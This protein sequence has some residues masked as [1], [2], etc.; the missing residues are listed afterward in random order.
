MSLALIYHR[1]L[2]PQI[3]STASNVFSASPPLSFNAT[4]H[5]SGKQLIHYQPLRPLYDEKAYSQTCS[6]FNV[7][8]LMSNR[9]LKL[10]I[11]SS[12]LRITFQV[13]LLMDVYLGSIQ[14]FCGA[15][16]I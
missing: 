11:H 15:R 5:C 2:L 14:P 13:H 16:Q 12:F 9:Y 8:S 7:E 10:L 4:Q 1:D 3:C 6:E